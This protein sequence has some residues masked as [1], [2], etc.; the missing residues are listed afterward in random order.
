MTRVSSFKVRDGKSGEVRKMDKINGEILKYQHTQIQ[1]SLQG[2][3]IENISW[4]PHHKYS[5][6]QLKKEIEMFHELQKYYHGYR[7]K[8]M[9][10]IMLLEIECLEEKLLDEKLSL[11][12]YKESIEYFDIRKPKTNPKYLDKRLKKILNSEK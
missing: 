2:M 7:T 5:L 6:N 8:K 12:G 10:K 1:E 4:K 9:N 11:Y 3:T